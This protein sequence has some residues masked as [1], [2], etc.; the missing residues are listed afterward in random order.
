[1]IERRGV[2]TEKWRERRF[3]QLADVGTD[4]EAVLSCGLENSLGIC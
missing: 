3:A 4:A 1:M 2:E